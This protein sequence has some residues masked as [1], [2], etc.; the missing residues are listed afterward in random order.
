MRK[1]IVHADGSVTNPTRQGRRRNAPD[2][3]ETTSTPKRASTRPD[4]SEWG[5]DRVHEGACSGT[6]R[7]A[8]VGTVIEAVCGGS[9]GRVWRWDF[10]VKHWNLLT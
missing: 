10:D 9:C 6:V 1:R 8:R 5:A 2:A 4:G 7:L 3:Q